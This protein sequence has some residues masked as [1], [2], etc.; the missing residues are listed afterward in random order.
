MSSLSYL[1]YI[2]NITKK[3]YQENQTGTEGIDIQEGLCYYGYCYYGS[4][5]FLK[6]TSSVGISGICEIIVCPLACVK[7]FFS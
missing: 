7:Y 1:Y 4:L 5:L 3:S 6:L 2:G